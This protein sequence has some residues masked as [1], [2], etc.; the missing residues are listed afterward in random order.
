ME[1]ALLGTGLMGRPLG[2]RLLEAN[3][4]LIVFNRTREKA[5][6]LRTLGAEIVESAHDAIRSSKCV[7]LVLANAQAIHE[8]LLS[9]PSRAELSHRTVIQVGTISPTESIAINR[10][11]LKAGGEYLEAPVLGSITE[12]KEGTLIL[13]VG[14]SPEQFHRWSGLLKSLGPEPLLIGPVGHASGLKLALNQL[15]A[16]LTAA[17]AL[18]LGFVQR[19]GI[20]VDLFMRI[21][22]GSFLHAPQFDRKFERMIS[23]N[24][25]NPYFPTKHLVKDVELFL[26]EA[27]SMNIDTIGLEGI[28]RLLTIT[29]DRG[30]SEED[31]SAMFDVVT[32][33]I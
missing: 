5:E 8:V 21:L 31:Y 32:Q 7:I 4:R 13:M 30:Y 15:I 12:A 23:K 19:K 9:P 25:S 24:H 10:E 29:L 33:E 20:D 22:R 2:E 27:K 28:R 18:S 16:S 6:P 3:H 1:I 14:A 17:F 11:V 26:D